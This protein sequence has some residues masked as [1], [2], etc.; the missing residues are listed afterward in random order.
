MI[1]KLHPKE[2]GVLQRRI[3]QKLNVNP[4]IVRDINILTLIKSCDLLLTSFST[5]ILEAMIIGTPVIIL[6]FINKEFPFSGKYLFSEEK[7]VKTT[8]HQESLTKIIKQLT[9]NPDL[10]KKYSEELKINA[11]KF[12]F[13][14]GNDPPTEKIINLISKSIQK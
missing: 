14:D 2:T 13:Y 6:D 7:Y 4:I 9:T 5:T 3:L 8:K 12:S 11:D 10:L 1:I